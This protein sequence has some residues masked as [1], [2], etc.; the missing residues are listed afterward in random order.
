M[1]V[2]LDLVDLSQS[3]FV[4]D[5]RYYRN[6]WADCPK[7]LGRASAVDALI[8][9]KQKLPQGWNFKV[10]DMYRTR[11]VQVRMIGSFRNRIREAH[12]K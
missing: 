11:E 1:L 3:G 7:I 12:P 9:A 2:A 4:V 6:G 10:W 8:R 5:P